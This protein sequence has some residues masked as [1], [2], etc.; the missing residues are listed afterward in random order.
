VASLDDH[1]RLSPHAQFYPR[2]KITA[3]LDYLRQL[4]SGV[5]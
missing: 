4:S 5:G 2:Q 3:L 1:S